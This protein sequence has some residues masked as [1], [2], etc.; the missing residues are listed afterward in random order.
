MPFAPSRW[1]QAWKI[2]QTVYFVARVFKNVSFAKAGNQYSNVAWVS[3]TF[4][5][6]D[7]CTQLQTLATALHSRYTLISF[8][9][10]FNIE[11]QNEKKSQSVNTISWFFAQLTKVLPDVAHWKLEKSSQKMPGKIH[12]SA[13]LSHFRH[14]FF[15]RHAFIMW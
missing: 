8:S 7:I 14:C 15:V 4:P 11:K 1:I 3:H 12:L 9:I 6:I 5:F 10:T 2:D 13:L